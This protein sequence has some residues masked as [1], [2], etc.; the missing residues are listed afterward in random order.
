VIAVLEPGR[1]ASVQD[2]GRV[3][4]THLG[5]P[6]AGAADNLS[7]RQANLLVGNL[8]YVPALEMTLGGPVLHFEVDAVVALTGGQLDAHLDDAPV[9][10]YQSIQVRA[11][12]I[13]NCGPLRTGMRAYLAV[14]GG[15]G[16]PPMLGSAS[17]DTLAHLGPP[18]L[19]GGETLNV[20]SHRLEQG[21]YWRAPPEFGK[22]TMLRV[23]VG[24]HAEW[25]TAGALAEFL[26]GEFEVRSDSDRSGL[27][28]AGA[29]LSRSNQNELRSQ[30]M[31][32]GAVQV[33]GDGQPIILLCTHGA[34]GGYPVIA[35]VIAADLPRLG[36]LCP[37]AKLC[38]QSVSREQALEALRIAE[39]EF[40]NGLVSADP[41]LLAA[42]RLMALAKSYPALR[43]ASL[44]VDGRRVSMRR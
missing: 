27:R 3:G 38:F 23:V 40:H 17:S 43:A 12:Q 29:R 9:A 33:P 18:V 15:F 26:Q 13:L 6:H 37:G 31:V 41:G 39:A 10:M 42:R 11:G 16:V 30:G 44:Q 2:G 32:N 14:A 36:Q 35:V 21:W 20:Q 24:P 1:F 8:E 7:L 22:R 34:T 28:L 5:V 25:F 19:C 4:F